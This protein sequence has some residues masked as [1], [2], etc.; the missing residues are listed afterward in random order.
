M[1]EHGGSNKYIPG[2]SGNSISSNAILNKTLNNGTGSG[3][4]ASF[5]SSNHSNN[6]NKSLNSEMIKSSI[7]E[8]NNRDFKKEDFGYK[9]T[10]IK[11]FETPRRVPRM[12]EPM[13]GNI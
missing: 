3:T 8:P 11:T 7:H 6:H 13:N 1:N 9:D 4:T 12:S 5:I 2:T 10:K